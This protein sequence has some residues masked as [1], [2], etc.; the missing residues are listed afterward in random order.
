MFDC[1]ESEPVL[2][3]TVEA[4][5]QGVLHPNV[6]SV[7]PTE[8][9]ISWKPPENGNGIILKYDLIKQRMK[10]CSQMLVMVW[11]ILCIPEIFLKYENMFTPKIRSRLALIH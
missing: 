1:T 10:P 5:P 3:T 4:L 8:V 9:D 11:L 6:N 2:V 7:S